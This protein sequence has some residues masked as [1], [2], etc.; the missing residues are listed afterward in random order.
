MVPPLALEDNL[1]RVH[2]VGLEMKGISIEYMN[3][4]RL[5]EYYKNGMS[6]MCKIYL[7]FS[8]FIFQAIK[9][10]K[11]IYT[12][13]G[14]QGEK[15]EL[16]TGVLEEII[17]IGF[18]VEYQIENHTELVINSPTYLGYQLGSLRYEDHGLSLYRSTIQ[19]ETNGG[20]K[21]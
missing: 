1:R 4:P 21:I 13:Y 11:L 12:F 17:E 20:G 3:A 5:T 14:S 8:G 15:I 16:N 7:D 10:D 2:T 18:E 9:V 6:E 19:L